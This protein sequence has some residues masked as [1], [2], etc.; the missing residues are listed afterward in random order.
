MTRPALIVHGGAGNIPASEHE[1]YLRGCR[2]AAQTAWKLLENGAS[3]L[4]A[5]EV[6][7]RIL[8]DDPTYDAGYGSVLNQQ[9]EVETD[10]IIMDGRDLRIG[11]VI[12]IQHIANPIT[13]AR[14]VMTE[15]PHNIL[16]GEGARLFAASQGIPF[17]TMEDMISPVARRHFE[18]KK[19]GVELTGDP[20]GTVGAVAL[21]VNGD[22][23]AATSTGGINYKMV[24]RVG[25]S[26]LVGSGAYAD[27]FTGAVSATGHGEDIMRVCLSKTAADAIAH[28]KTAQEAAEYAIKI[29]VDRVH[30][31]GGLIVVDKDGNVGFAHST[32]EISV[33]WVGWNAEGQPTIHA[34]IRR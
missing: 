8:E 21:D 17:T 14:L 11:A 22:L 28:G 15:T 20:Q 30:G 26:P 3:A 7:V 32:P 4:H 23:A 9:G 10:A 29:L 13:L 1:A 27:N 16:A 18:A 19:Q 2:L 5:V 25:D 6:A 12:C 33:A 31:E 24:G 34:A